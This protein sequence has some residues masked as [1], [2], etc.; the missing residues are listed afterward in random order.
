MFKN[1]RMVAAA[2]AVAGAMALA[3]ASSASAFTVTNG[4]AVNATAGTSK[5][6]V[7]SSV[8]LTC[9]TTTASGTINNGTYSLGAVV[10]T[11]TP[12]FSSCKGPLNTNFTVLCTAANLQVNSLTGTG[13]LGQLNGISCK[14]T[15]TLLG[16]SATAAG[17]VPGEYFNSDTLTVGLPQSLTVSGTTCPAGTL[18]NGTATFTDSSGNPLDYTLTGPNYPVIS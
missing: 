3:G 15:F 8:S 5:L 11:I 17:S 10:G 6:T 9:T 12:A 7:N 18:P 2:T 4:G 1:I 14:I 13:A 16:C